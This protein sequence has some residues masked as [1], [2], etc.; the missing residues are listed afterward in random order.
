MHALTLPRDIPDVSPLRYAGFFW[1]QGACVLVEVSVGGMAFDSGEVRSP[2]TRRWVSLA[3]CVW[4]VGVMFYSAPLINGEL[5][6]AGVRTVTQ[7]GGPIS[8]T[9]K[10]AGFVRYWVTQ[11]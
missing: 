7:S 4:V 1:I 2:Q 11:S 5:V 8:V 9:R 3:R 10:M 6:K